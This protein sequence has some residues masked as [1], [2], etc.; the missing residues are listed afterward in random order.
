MT[1]ATILPTWYP[2]PLYAVHPEKGFRILVT[3][4]R[5][6]PLADRDFIHQVLRETWKHNCTGFN[7]ETGERPVTRLCTVVDGAC[8]Y[9][10]VDQYAHEWAMS[11][12]LGV[13]S[14]R[15][16]AAFCGSK[17]LGKERNAEMV[18]SGADVAL[19][20]PGPGSGWGTMDCVKKVINADIPMKI[21]PYQSGAIERWRTTRRIDG[22]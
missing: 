3:G 15:H 12:G 4:W 16:P 21:F 13:K 2:G 9:G 19:A 18:A 11:M 10:G 5:F 8:P 17:L 6:W 14:E 1:A 22:L 20:F 7:G